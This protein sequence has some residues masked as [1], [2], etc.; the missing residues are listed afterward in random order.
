MFQ[1][2]FPQG[3]RPL[4][5]VSIISDSGVSIHVPARG[6]TSKP[7]RTSH[8]GLIQS[9]YPQG[10]RPPAKSTYRKTIAVSIHVPARGTTGIA[11]VIAT[12]W[13]TFQSTFPQGERPGSRPS[14]SWRLNRFNPRSRKGNDCSISVSHHMSNSFNPRSRKGNDTDSVS[15]LFHITVSI[16][17]PARGTTQ[18]NCIG[19]TQFIVSIHVPARGTTDG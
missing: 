18:Q 15:V 19:D 17:V 5:G 2:T 12:L 6:T 9:T 1:S 14:P 3:E 13:N 11:A 8:S 16:H 7:S 10:E 4:S